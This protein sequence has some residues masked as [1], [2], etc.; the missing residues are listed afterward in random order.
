MRVCRS[1]PLVLILLLLANIP[2]RAAWASGPYTQ[3]ALA[4]LSWV[5]A[6][7]QADGSFP[8]FG[9]SSTADAVYAICAVG[10][11][12]NGFLRDGHSPI[13]YLG[14]HA[15][16]FTSVAGSLGKA[17]LAAVCAGK[18]PRAF[19]GVD[20]VATL[21]KA[22]D[23]STGRYGSDLAGHAFALLALT[24]VGRPIPTAAVTWI[25]QAQTP[26][27]GWSW[28][29][30]PAAGGADTNSSA[31]AMQALLAAGVSP[32]DPALRAAL[33]YLH[34]QQNA[35]GGFP[36]VKPSPYGTDTDANSTAYVV[37]A[38]LAAGEDPEGPAWTVEGKTP[39]AALLALQQPSGGFLWQA[40]V[41]GENAL[42]TY[43][44]IVALMLKPFPLARA[45]VG[46]VPAILPKTG[47]AESWPAL[48]AGVGAVALSVGLALRRRAAPHAG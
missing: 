14:D 38:L 17:I 9:A 44:A 3:A 19:G 27:G 23:P 12:P 35:D 43:Q 13:S 41:P 16:E 2:I 37:Q 29:G 31:L 20:L 33:A 39:L 11:D 32:A 1:L 40:A 21:E 6:Q 45:M 28:S 18:D 4:A 8:G 5:A 24:S 30:D 34:A 47:L 46:E 7:Q 10:G 36:Y 42:A 48:L 15:G 26:E 22:R 25:R